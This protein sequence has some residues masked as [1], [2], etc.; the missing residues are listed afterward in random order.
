MSECF[1]ETKSSGGRVN[2]ELD[3]SIYTKKVDIKI[4]TSVDNSKQKQ[5]FRGVHRK[6]FSENLQ[7]IYWRT[8][9]VKCD[10]KNVSKKVYCNNI[11]AWVFFCRFAKKND[12]VRS[13]SKVD[14]LDIYKKSTD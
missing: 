6:R 5:S 13:K 9:L 1:P 2:V 4:A 8:P 10:F 14:K 12:L 3:L 7:Q 11:S